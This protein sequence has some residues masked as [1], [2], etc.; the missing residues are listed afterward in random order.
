MNNLITVFKALSDETRLK[1]LII[2]STRNICAKGLSRHLGISE[3]AVS[4]H[5]RI[6][7]DAGLI[8]GEKDGYFVRYHLKPHCF[9]EL[10][11]FTHQMVLQDSFDASTSKLFSDLDCLNACGK[12]Q[13][14][15][16]GSNYEGS[17]EK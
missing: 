14:K 9:D 11:A 3:P 5:I 12:K 13:R 15:C 2:L 1:I 10:E 16:C 17:L 8:V 4:Q 7:K 6:L